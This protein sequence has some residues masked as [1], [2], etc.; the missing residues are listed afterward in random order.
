MQIGEE[1]AVR[2]IFSRAQEEF[3]ARLLA[4]LSARKMKKLLQ[5]MEIC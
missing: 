2:E 3:S 1:H 4:M 5:L